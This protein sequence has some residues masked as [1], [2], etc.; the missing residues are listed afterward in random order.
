MNI[1]SSGDDQPLP[2]TVVVPVRNEERNLADCLSR[3][4]EFAAVVVVDS[5]STDRTEQIARDANATF[6]HFVWNGGFPKKRNWTLLN[7][8]FTTP[9]VLFLD[10]DEYVTPGFVAEL[11]R[12]LPQSRHA[13]YWIRFANHFMGRELRYGQPM[14]KLSLIRVGSGLYE[15]I[16][17][18]EWSSLD[19]EVHEHPVL[20]GSVGECASKIDHND[21]KGLH[22]YIARHNEYSSWEAARFARL[23]VAP[24][25]SEKFTLVQRR[26][27]RNLDRW[28]LAPAYFLHSF[29]WKQ[30]FR[31]GFTGFAFA[32]MKAIYF[33]QIRLKILENRDVLSGGQPLDPKPACGVAS[34]KGLQR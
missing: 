32:L 23:A 18:V 14:K 9:W 25:A 3:L 7:H 26:K 6:L 29:V 11:R 15:R 30:G 10:A 13:G 16:D 20:E 21:F 2:V 1:R 5:G 24:E 28:W 17:E 19:M 27:Y 33:F 34:A 12:E 8:R 4:G 31:D 22:A